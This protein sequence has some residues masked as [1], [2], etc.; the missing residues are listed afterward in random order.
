MKY[1]YSIMLMWSILGAFYGTQ[2]SDKY[3]YLTFL[4]Y[5]VHVYW[6]IY[7]TNNL[8]KQFKL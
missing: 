1:I 2:I 5:Y 4:C 7:W 8:L 3:F 6:A